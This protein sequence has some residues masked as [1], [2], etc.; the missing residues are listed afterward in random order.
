MSESRVL[1]FVR[2]VPGDGGFVGLPGLERTVLSAR[3]INSN[4]GS[5]SFVTLWAKRGLKE[6]LTGILPRL[7]LVIEEMRFTVLT[8]FVA[9][10][11]MTHTLAAINVTRATPIAAVDSNSVQ[12]PVGGLTDTSVRPIPA[13]SRN[14]R[15]AAG[16]GDSGIKAPIIATLPLIPS[17]AQNQTCSA[18][19]A[20]PNWFL[21]AGEGLTFQFA[22]VNALTFTT[23]FNWMFQVRACETKPIIREGWPLS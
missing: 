7:G 3:N 17:F 13:N 23:N 21:P 16:T 5:A 14:T 20:N 10:Q 6:D 19:V 22:T 8:P 4:L 1:S 18:L 15:A 2:S 11:A 12:L 9:N